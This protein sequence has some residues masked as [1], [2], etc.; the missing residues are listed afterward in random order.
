MKRFITALLAM[1]LVVSLAACKG[2]GGEDNEGETS[3]DVAAQSNVDNSGTTEVYA[4]ADEE[5][6]KFLLSEFSEEVTGLSGDVNDY[7]FSITEVQFNGKTATKAQAYAIG[8]NN[9]KGIFFIVGD[10]CYKYDEAQNKYFELTE[11][12]A[13]EIK[14]DVK[15]VEKTETVTKADSSATTEDVRTEDKIAEENKSVLTARYEKYDLSKIG[16]TKPISQ[17]EFQATSKSAT[18][19]DGETVYIIYLLENGKY[20][21]FTF[22]VGPEKDYYL[23]NATGEYKPLS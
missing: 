11:K 15:V 6:V 20:T 2:N 3:S 8:D 19:V 18:A 22:A 21:E 17:Y 13:V 14:D 5:R 1:A 7:F 23:D 9:V 10:V 16:I 12:K 4:V